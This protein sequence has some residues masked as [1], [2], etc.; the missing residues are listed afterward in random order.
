MSSSSQ[1]LQPILTRYRCHIPRIAYSDAFFTTTM[2]ANARL[3]AQQYRGCWKR[4]LLDRPHLRFDGGPRGPRGHGAGGHAVGLGREGM[5]WAWGGRACC[6]PC[7]C[8]CHCCSAASVVLGVCC[9]PPCPPPSPELLRCA[10]A[11]PAGIYVSRNTYLKRGVVEWN[12][13]NAAH[14][15]LYFRYCRFFP[16]GTF[17]YR[18]SPEPLNR[19]HRTL[20]P[21]TQQQQQQQQRQAAAQRAGGGGQRRG[22]RD[23][24]EREPEPNHIMHFGRFKQEVHGW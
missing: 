10:A 3:V 5:P 24:G 20:A 9:I 22:G 1:Q 13:K 21:P 17:V 4:M 12:V 8:R 19:V 23:R 18:T 11:R 6:G 14:M 7:R 2:E 15:V 16:D